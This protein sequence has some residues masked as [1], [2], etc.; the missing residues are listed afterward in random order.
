MEEK[1]EHI[2]R[3]LF[4]GCLLAGRTTSLNEISNLSKNKSLFNSTSTMFSFLWE[5]QSETFHIENV[6]SNYS[7][8]DYYLYL[9]GKEG[10][11]LGSGHSA[12]IEFE[13]NCIKDLE[14]IIFVIDSQIERTDANLDE[15]RILSDTL[16]YLERN[17]EEIPLVFQINKRDLPNIVSV[18]EIK[19]EFTWEGKHKYVESIATQG[20]GV[21][22]AF[23]S[24]IEMIILG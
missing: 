12:S 22:E 2:L 7:I 11:L 17:P 16:K 6:K 24:L 18:E 8:G 10:F 14:G 4:F 21:K 13:I 19:K 23:D 1:S 3:V 15:Y 5:I 9:S 20:I